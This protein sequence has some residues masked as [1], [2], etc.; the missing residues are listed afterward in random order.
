MI[1]KSVLKG[2]DKI[3]INIILIHLYF[4]KKWLKVKIIQNHFTKD[5]IKIYYQNH[6]IFQIHK[7]DNTKKK[8]INTIVKN[9]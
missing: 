8:P 9:V 7:L 4:R 5:H 3:I 2:A 1:S 6:N